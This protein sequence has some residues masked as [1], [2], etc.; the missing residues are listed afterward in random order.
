[1]ARARN[2]KPS[3]FTDDELAEAGPLARLL[4]QGLWCMADR[5]GRLE[6]RPKKLKAEILPYDVCSV[7]KLLADLCQRRY[8]IRYEHEGKRYIQVRQFKKHQNPHQKEPASTIPAPD[9]HHTKP[10]AST[11]QAPCKPDAQTD[12]GTVH[13][14]EIPERAGR[15]PPSPF[16]IPPSP[17]LTT[18][19][20]SP[21]PDSNP[22]AKPLRPPPAEKPPKDGPPTNEVW[23]AYSTAYFGR[24]GSEPVRNAMV[25][26]Q[27]TNFVSRIGRDEA[28]AVAA[29][30]LQNRSSR[31]VNAGHSVGMLVQDAEKLRTEWANGRSVTSTEAARMDRGD[32]NPFV[33]MLKESNNGPA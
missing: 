11:R 9:E 5:E 32:G 25:N 19:S 1:M 2:L 4:F 21:L 10:S 26:G 16:L 33:K 13:A 17:L 8:I 12:T 27:L 6:D 20:P 15:I 7:E 23:S 3:F 31:Y 28:P 30:Y 18:D 24:Y 22:K 14:E 29:S